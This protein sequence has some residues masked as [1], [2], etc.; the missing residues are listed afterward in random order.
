MTLPVDE[1]ETFGGFVFG[2]LGTIPAD[3]SRLEID[4]CGLHIKVLEIREHR[5][6]RAL[7]CINE[8]DENSEN[9]DDKNN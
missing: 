4:A 9:A 8:S 5:M 1:Y 3:G 6:E 7:V 2:Y